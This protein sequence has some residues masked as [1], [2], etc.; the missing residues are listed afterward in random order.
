MR[1]W[2]ASAQQRGPGGPSG[3]GGAS[4]PGGPGGPGTHPREGKILA[5]RSKDM[6][7]PRQRGRWL[8]VGVPSVLGGTFGISSFIVLG[9]SSLIGGAGLVAPLLA[10]LGIG[11][12]VGGGS[13][14]LLRNR[15]PQPARVNAASTEMPVGTRTMLEKIV[16]ATT[17]QRRRLARVRRKRPDPAVKPVL[18]R[19]DALLQRINSL[20]SSA[21]LQSRRPSDADVMVL[22]GMALRYIPDLVSALEDTVVFLTPSTGA[23]RDKAYANL[24]SIDQQLTALGDDIERIENDVVAGVTRSL[25]VHSEFLKN[26]LAAQQRSPLIDG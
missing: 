25:D 6:A 24:H 7:P 18:N 10:G 5:P 15:R 8:T 14:F 21:S 22:E 19:V 20:M 4:G 13:A 1:S 12:V 2:T 17:R 26:R 9:V 11:V 23:A 3:P 16:K